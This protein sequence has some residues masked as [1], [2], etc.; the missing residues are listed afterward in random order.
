MDKNLPYYEVCAGFFQGFLQKRRIDGGFWVISALDLC[1][2]GKFGNLIMNTILLSAQAFIHPQQAIIDDPKI[3]HHLKQVLRVCPK[4]TL[5][6]GC[7]GGKLGTAVVADMQD[8]RVILEAV[9]LDTAPPPKL[10]VTVILALPRPKVLRRLIMDM[11]AI[12]VPRI[13]L[14]NSYRTE[15]SYWQSPMLSHLDDFVQEGLAQGV[16][17]IAPRIDLQKRFKP[18]VEDEL[19]LL[20]KPIALFHPYHATPIGQYLQH[21]T[22][23]TIIIGAE[24]GF[25]A[26]EVAL[27]HKHGADVVDL[28]ARIL[29]TEAAVN[30]V[31]GRLL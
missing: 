15:K 28:G 25:I 5:K 4:D 8:T 1:Y 24:G 2:D 21:K 31:L 19:A 11:T 16:D 13:T 18:F 20:P 12:G 29:R 14:L 10:E 17:C 3:I 26:Y 7:L 27:L 23:K 9:C 22:P 6:I 30:A